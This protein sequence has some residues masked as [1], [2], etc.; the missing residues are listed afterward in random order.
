M[1]IRKMQSLDLEFV[2]AWRNH[3]E[4]RRFML[5]QHKITSTEHR[6]WFD[7]AVKDETYALLVIEENE[8]PVGCVIF[9]GVQPNS[10]TSWGFYT[11]PASPAGT[12]TRVCSIALDYIFNE[13]RVH[14]V[15]GQVLDYNAASI[16]IHE[17]LG[18]ILE[19]TF[20]EHSLVT[21]V[22]HSLFC[23]GLLSSEWGN[24]IRSEKRIR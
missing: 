18:F 8:I 6:A 24:E 13:H 12:G 5:T 3:S 15:M 14:K 11:S 22:H 19:G 2:L 9:S 17:R 4:V 1:V 20:R 16:R 23:F 10:T 21:E 7:R